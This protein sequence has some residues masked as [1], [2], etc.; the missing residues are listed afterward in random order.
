M[1]RNLGAHPAQLLNPQFQNFAIS[2]HGVSF[3]NLKILLYLLLF[4]RP[5]IS[6]FYQPANCFFFWVSNPTQ[7]FLEIGRNYV[8]IIITVSSSI[9]VLVSHNVF[10]FIYFMSLSHGVNKKAP[11]VSSLQSPPFQVF[12][13]FVCCFTTNNLSTFF[14]SDQIIA[15]NNA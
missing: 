12:T 10:C 4:S 13:R 2:L 14:C 15:E 11:P 7:L 3:H 1:T 8:P 9:T 5:T 6:K